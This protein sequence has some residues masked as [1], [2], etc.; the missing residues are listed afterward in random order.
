MPSAY[1]DIL[2]MI[3]VAG[4]SCIAL[5]VI[6]NMKGDGKIEYEKKLDKWD[7]RLLLLGGVLIAIGFSTLFFI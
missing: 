6:R 1:S 7:K 3:F 5:V 2:L 4:A